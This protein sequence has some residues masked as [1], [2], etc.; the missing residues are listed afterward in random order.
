MIITTA[1]KYFSTVVLILRTREISSAFSGINHQTSIPTEKCFK[2]APGKS[3]A[4][5]WVKE[6]TI[7]LNEIS[8]TLRHHSLPFLSF[9]DYS[10]W[11]SEVQRMF[12]PIKNRSAVY[13]KVFKLACVTARK[14]DVKY[15]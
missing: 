8:A 2:L 14:F 4:A 6:N 15:I 7:K 13:L 3:R 5:V 12:T 11:R 9:L 1:K 10:Y